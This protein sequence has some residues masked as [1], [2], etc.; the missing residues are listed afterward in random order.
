MSILNVRIDCVNETQADLLKDYLESIDLYIKDLEIED[1]R[2]TCVSKQGIVDI[3]TDFIENENLKPMTIELW[4]DDM[5][6][7]EADE[8]GSLDYIELD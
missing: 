4:P 2:I 6:Y 3:I 1:E 5:D 7:D 8:D